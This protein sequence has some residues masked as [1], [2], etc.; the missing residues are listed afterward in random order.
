MKSPR[1]PPSEGRGR[2]GAQ[3]A[4]DAASEGRPGSGNEPSEG[5]CLRTEK[6]RSAECLKGEDRDASQQ[7]TWKPQRGRRAVLVLA[8][9]ASENRRS[10]RGRRKREDCSPGTGTEKGLAGDAGCAEPRWG[11][12][13]WGTGPRWQ[14]EGCP[15]EV[16]DVSSECGP[17]GWASRRGRPLRGLGASRLAEHPDFPKRDGKD[18]RGRERTLRITHTLTL[19]CWLTG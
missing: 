11:A 7:V 17:G 1:W 2:R 4:R 8:S 6:R 12:G 3:N 16:A 18:H 13:R 19:S 10:E 9:P 15:W 5:E 14:S